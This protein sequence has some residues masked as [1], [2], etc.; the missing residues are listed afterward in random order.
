MDK[1][2]ETE[3][4]DQEDHFDPE[5]LDFTL[6]GEEDDVDPAPDKKEE[7]E[8]EKKEDLTASE[9]AKVRAEYETLKA[10][11]DRLENER[12]QA[13]IREEEANR[14]TVQ[15]A[16]TQRQGDVKREKDALR[17]LQVDFEEAK[18]NQDIDKIKALTRAIGEKTDLIEAAQN[19]ISQWQPLLNNRTTP[20]AEVKATPKP[21]Q[22]QVLAEQWAKENSWVEDP[23]FKDKKDKA[24]ELYNKLRADGYD[25][26]KLSFWTH[27]NSELK[28]F[29]KPKEEVKRRTPPAVRPAIKQGGAS[30]MSESKKKADREILIAVHRALDRRGVSKNSPDF[31]KL[32][33]SYYGTFKREIDKSRESNG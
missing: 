29:D 16:I 18:A 21:E 15:T 20:K 28:E 22:W 19:D 1:E 7:K 32:Q 8:E 6:D 25:H 26:S 2:F 5:E 4:G 23:K 24:V 11:K 17:N 14:I 9:L 13:A 27:I 30:T 10:E 33:K 3:L 12:E 31:E